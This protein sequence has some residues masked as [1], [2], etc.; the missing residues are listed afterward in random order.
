MHEHTT[1]EGPHEEKLCAKTCCPGRINLNE[2]KPLVKDAKYICT[3]CGR[4]A[5][6]AESLCSPQAI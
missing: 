4:G 3:E 1:H 6:R 5:A 2:L